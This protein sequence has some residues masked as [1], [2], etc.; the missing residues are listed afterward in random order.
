MTDPDDI[1]FRSQQAIL[2][3]T[4]HRLINGKSVFGVAGDGRTRWTSASSSSMTPTQPWRDRGSVPA[5][6][7]SAHT[8]YAGLLELFAAD[9][10]GQSLSTWEDIRSGVTR[11]CP[12]PVLVLGG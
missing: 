2:V 10:R 6:D 11:P 3:T 4:F 8:A 9:L 12:H 1:K 7:P 5:D